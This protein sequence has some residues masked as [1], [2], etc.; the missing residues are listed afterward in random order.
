MESSKILGLP[1]QEGIEAIKKLDK[2]IKLDIEEVYSTKK[3]I[4]DELIEPRII[5]VSNT[6]SVITIVVGY[7]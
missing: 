3:D 6:D 4:K 5:R 7:F 2:T 1:L